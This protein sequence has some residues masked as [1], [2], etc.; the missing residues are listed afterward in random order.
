M[1]FSTQVAL[2]LEALGRGGEEEH[3]KRGM[4][5]KLFHLRRKKVTFGGTMECI[6]M[7]GMEQ[8]KGGRWNVMEWLNGRNGMEQWKGGKFFHLRRQ[9]IFHKWNCN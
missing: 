2:L 3:G 9:K 1:T 4:G 5:G 6:G 8:W 7:N